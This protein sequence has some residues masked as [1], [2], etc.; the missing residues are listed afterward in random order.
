MLLPL[1]G[2]ILIPPGQKR[3]NFARAAFH[4]NRKRAE[5][6]ST[7]MSRKDQQNVSK[8]GHFLLV[9]FCSVA[10]G[11]WNASAAP[12]DLDPTFSG[13]GKVV[14]WSGQ[15][16]GVAIQPD[17]KIVVVGN[18]T[19]GPFDVAVARYNPD[20]SPDV[21]FGNAGKVSILLRIT[22]TYVLGFDVAISPDGKIVVTC[23]D[24]DQG[25]GAIVRLNNNGS[26]D[27]S[28]NNGGL[29]PTLGGFYSATVQPDGRILTSAGVPFNSEFGVHVRRY[30][31]D[32]SLDTTFG[33]GDG[34]TDLDIATSH[35][36]IQADGKIVA[37]GTA[38]PLSFAVA[39][40]N[41]DGTADESFGS[42]GLATASIGT[43]CS[44]TS[45]TSLA[46][47]RIVAVGRCFVNPA[48]TDYSLVRFNPN[49]SLDTTFD[50]DGIVALPPLFSW[51]H[52]FRNIVAQA[53]GKVVVS[54]TSSGG[55]TDDYALIRYR[56]D[57]SLD[58]SF[59]G[60][61]GIATVD[62][63]NSG[64]HAHGMV[65]DSQGRAVVVGQSG[66]AFAIARVLL[67]SH[68]TPFDYD[69]D[70]KT[71][72]SVWRDVPSMDFT[73][74]WFIAE[75]ESGQVHTT[76]MEDYGRIVPADYD[77]DG[78]TDLAVAGFG[79]ADP[80]PW[81]IWSQATGFS[82][83]QYW[84]F[85]SDYAV[86]ADFDGDGRADFAVWRPSEG[87]W[88]I[89]STNT[90][91]IRVQQ[92]GLPGD[93]PVPADFDGDGKTDL[94]VFRP[95]EGKWYIASIATGAITVIGWG[96]NGDI[97][98]PG[99]YNGDGRADFAVSRPSN[100]TWYRMHSND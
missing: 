35:L 25:F 50:N 16:R 6:R 92:W 87:K 14:D 89:A 77:G 43:D 41:P 91:E 61:D 34:A 98:V 23:Y 48:F 10:L 40:F 24:D 56:L 36:L 90:G 31:A 54:G 83:F 1:I 74:F 73:G 95:S 49:G 86:P 45:L 65:L 19:Y 63:E 79:K 100:N 22:F 30:N 52:S 39:R 62:F 96:L 46:D 9:I 51:T 70:G 38:G 93:K 67:K 97:P 3:N 26:L 60:S 68:K 29:V 80:V 11:N 27:T 57:G 8:I 59:G 85:P 28:F 84:G 99:D 55:S 53:D 64:D 20:G 82:T 5:E 76:E 78:R 75:S 15:A 71:D 18:S 66:G 44:A 42:G 4:P 33:G 13:D 69:G 72:F 32:G 88:Y 17:G 12:G 37:A 21:T 2:W 81:L 58:T 7:R 94:A 47:G